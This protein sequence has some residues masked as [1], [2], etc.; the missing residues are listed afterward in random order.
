MNKSCS[1][2]KPGQYE[3][4]YA[5]TMSGLCHFATGI[6]VFDPKF[7]IA[8]PGTDQSVYFL[9]TQKQKRLTA[10]HPQIQ[11]LLYN[12]EDTDNDMDILNDELDQFHLELEGDATTTTPIKKVHFSLL[13]CAIAKFHMI[14][15]VVDLLL[16][17]DVAS[18]SS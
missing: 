2:E 8:A 3:H 5:F 18:S 13:C 15:L 9:F 1:K 14:N 11:E 7:N 17:R 4:H 16:Y 6:N 12:K 10:L